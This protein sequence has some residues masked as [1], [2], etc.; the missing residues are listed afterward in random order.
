MAKDK[1]PKPW[2][3]RGS[4]V[5]FETP[6]LTLREDQIEYTT[7]ERAGQSDTYTVLELG[8]CVGVLPFVSGR[9]CGPVARRRCQQTHTEGEATAF[10][11]ES[12]RVRRGRRSG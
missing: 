9:E 11:R 12:C 3:T 8:H 5:L 6:W 7:P 10:C 2:E 4:R 1:P